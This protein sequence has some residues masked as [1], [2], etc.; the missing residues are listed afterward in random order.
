M[1]KTDKLFV[2]LDTFFR[3]ISNQDA[4]MKLFNLANKE[5][6]RE[7]NRTTTPKSVD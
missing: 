7:T 4:L 5:R 6:E 2:V 3:K 1:G